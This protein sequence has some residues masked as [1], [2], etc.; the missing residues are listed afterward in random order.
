[1]IKSTQVLLAAILL[2]TAIQSCKHSKD[3]PVENISAHGKNQSHNMGQ[4]CMNCHEPGGSGSGWFSIAGTAY[5]NNQSQTQPDI[6]VKLYTGVN[7]TGSLEYTIEGDSRGNFYTTKYINFNQAL[8]PVIEKDSSVR[9]MSTSL[10]TGA[11]NSC[12]GV[13]T[14]KLMIE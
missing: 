10:T 9:F 3:G 1:M 13:S 8:Y 5:N 6:T 2:I 11:C 14:N 4:N 12:H 7:R